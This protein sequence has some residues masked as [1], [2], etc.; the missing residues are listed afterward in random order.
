M[1]LAMQQARSGQRPILLEMPVTRFNPP[2]QTQQADEE[3]TASDNDPLIRCQHYLC[4]QGLWDEVW[5][6]ELYTHL[7]REV[8]R[9][10]QDAIRDIVI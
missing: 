7:S 6:H 5:A 1:Q 4:E 10:M 3:N 2:F 9:A 8:E